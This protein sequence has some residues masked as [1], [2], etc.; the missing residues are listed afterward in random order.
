M[1]ENTGF[2]LDNV[3]L[4]VSIKLTPAIIKCLAKIGGIISLYRKGLSVT[5]RTFTKMWPRTANPAWINKYRR[6]RGEIIRVAPT[7]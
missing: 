6:L 5:N 2:G 1:H 4:S 3:T 7:T